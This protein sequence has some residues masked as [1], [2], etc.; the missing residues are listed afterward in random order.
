MHIEIKADTRFEVRS[1]QDLPKLKHLM[2]AFRVKPNLSQIARNLGKDRRTVK[3]YY[4]GDLPLKT[5][6]KGSRIDPWYEEIYNLLY[7]QGSGHQIFYYKAHLWRYLKENR[8][9]TSKES[10]FRH[11]IRTHPEL[12]EYFKKKRKTAPKSSVRFETLPGEQAQVDWKEDIRY[13]TKDGEILRINVL[14][15]V[16]SFS[17]YKIYY[18]TQSRIR[19]VLMSCLTEFFEQ[20]G[21]VPHTL[22]FDN[23]KTVME[24][25]RTATS[26]GTVDEEFLRFSQDMGFQ[27]VTCM[28]NRP[29][30]KGKVEAQMKVLDEIHAYGG[31]YDMEGLREQLY[32]MNLRENME[33]CQGTGIAP[34]T[35]FE[36]E[37]KALA[38]LPRES[39]R[40]FY[41]IR[42]QHLKVNAQNMVSYKG[43]QYSV[44]LGYKGATLFL[45]VVDGF[46]SLYDTTEC[47]A[48]HAVS[49]KKLNYTLEHYEAHLWQVF[50]HPDRIAEKAQENL[51]KIGGVFGVK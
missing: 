12:E 40:A 22:L 38:P 25:A 20:M 50:P 34:L 2:E 6:N 31:L 47:V 23:M 13:V 7:S 33:I 29:Q 28:A 1:L 10:T 21:G 3:R 8:G 39:L 15:L 43:C 9:L 11:Y 32:K 18:L 41:K 44:P 51:Q 37:K 17:R 45:E 19:T 24:E 26:N 4:E 48:R 16:L 30:T 36:E 14:V 27:I 42:K 5:R 35:L 46:L 49:T